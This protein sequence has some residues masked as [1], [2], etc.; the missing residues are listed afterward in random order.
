MREWYFQA[1]GQELGPFSVA[2]LKSKVDS[3]QI[4]ADTMVRRGADGKWLFAERVKGLL[5]AKPVA[6]P[7]PAPVPL[8]IKNKSSGTIQV[9]NNSGS[10]PA[11]PDKPE[12]PHE[13]AAAPPR[14]I[15]ISLEADED[16]DAPP[17]APSVEFYDFVGFR[18]A[19]SPVL[20]HAVRQY[21]D[22]HQLSMTQ[23]NRRALAS[24]IKQPEL[25]SDLMIT[26][27]AVTPQPVNDKSN[28][29]HSHPLSDREKSEHATFRI[30]LFNCSRDP[31]DVTHGEFVP[32]S[33]ESREYDQVGARVITGIDHKGHVQVLLDGAKEGEAIP[34]PL[35]SAVAPR[36]ASTLT[37]W[38]RS[39]KK[40]S[41]SKIKG[42]IRIMGDRE[43]ALSERFTIIMHGDSQ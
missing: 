21:L 20:H 24:F 23:I 5:P 3:G 4:Q 35:K 30:T 15:A 7:E 39:A 43:V 17:K 36:Q 9:L 8:K 26:N 12:Q 31:L 27:M 34:F 11:I 6:E 40:P 32:E 37:V 33:I 42:Q 14:T 1:M 41:L 38:F 18:E 10:Y 16:P 28:A 13:P 2:E 19:I 29:D 22:E 25:A